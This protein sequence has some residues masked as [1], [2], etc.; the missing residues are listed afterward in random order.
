MRN[1]EREKVLEMYLSRHVR[2]ELGGL[3]IKLVSPSLVG[4]PDRML[5]LG[6]GRVVFVELKKE[7]KKPSKIQT[8]VQKKLSSLGFDVRT[9][10]SK[11]QVQQLIKDYGHRPETL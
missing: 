8:F 9:I 6:G 7:G 4:L 2:L 11:E 5:L 10:D 3:S 1:T